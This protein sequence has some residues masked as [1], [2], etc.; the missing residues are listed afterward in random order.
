MFS[1]VYKNNKTYSCN[2]RFSQVFIFKLYI[3]K[4]N[5]FFFYRILQT[6]LSLKGFKNMTK[7]QKNM[8]LS[9]L[10]RKCEFYTKTRIS[11]IFMQKDPFTVLQ[12]LHKIFSYFYNKKIYIKRTQSI[13]EFKKVKEFFKQNIRDEE[14]I[15]EIFKYIEDY[16]LLH[17]YRF[18]TVE[19][20]D[21]LRLARAKFMYTK[22]F[23]NKNRP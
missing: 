5:V 23:F 9:D 22:R 15:K 6:F 17:G 3:I 20:V 14:K 10:Q 4:L 21:L 13:T 7:F 12:D 16:E 19:G 18:E 8:F 2:R 1:L 11:A